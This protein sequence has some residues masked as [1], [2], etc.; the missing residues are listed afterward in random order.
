[1]SFFAT[2]RRLR[3]ETIDN[4]ETGNGRQSLI[5]NIEPIRRN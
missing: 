1:M 3:A 2:S 5:E 4:L